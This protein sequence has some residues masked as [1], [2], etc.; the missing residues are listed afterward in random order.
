MEEIKRNSVILNKS[1]TALLV[2]DIQDRIYKVMRKHER[3][4][5][6]VSKLIKGAKVLDLPIYYTEQ[7]PKGLGETVSFL[8]EELQGEAVQKLSFSCFGAEN[9]FK[10]LKDSNISQV[11]VCGIESHVCVQQTVLD[12][13]ANEF[14]VNLPANAVSSRNKMDYEIAIKRM[15]NKGA[16]VTTTEAVLFELLEV[17]GTPEFK[18]ISALVK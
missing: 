9:L 12:L 2:I 8:K 14:Q 18:Q 16:E 7:Y 3:M 10:E 4:L 5:E 6:N 13:L 11:V 15:E 1:T 17:S